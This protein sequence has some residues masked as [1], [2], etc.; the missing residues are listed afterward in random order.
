MIGA[1]EPRRRTAPVRPHHVRFGEI[2]KQESRARS[3]GNTRERSTAHRRLTEVGAPPP[4]GPSWSR[5]SDTLIEY[6]LG[7]PD[8]GY[9]SR[10][11][12]M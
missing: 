12:P 6:E 1:D 4:G 11:A 2:R 8:S 7:G 9:P 3:L 10:R 5:V